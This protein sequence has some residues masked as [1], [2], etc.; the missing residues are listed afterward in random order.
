M[1]ARRPY[2]APS[3]ALVSRG[4]QRAVVR[5]ARGG[6]R[7]AQRGVR[8]TARVARNHRGQKPGS[9]RR[10]GVVT[11][12]SQASRSASQR[13]KVRNGPRPAKRAAAEATLRALDSSH[14]TRRLWKASARS[15]A[16]PPTRR[17]LVAARSSLAAHPGAFGPSMLAVT[18]LASPPVAGYNIAREG[19]NVDFL[20]TS[21]RLPSSRGCR[22]LC[23]VVLVVTSRKNV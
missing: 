13:R 16:S 5:P 6:P 21:H 4:G 18:P 11:R 20:R 14:S 19:C 9:R 22:A 8:R 23:V 7:A 2:L 10:H 3:E 15:V 12:S 17:T 1:A